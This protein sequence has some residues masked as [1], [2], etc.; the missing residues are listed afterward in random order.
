MKLHKE[1]CGVLRHNLSEDQLSKWKHQLVENAAS[2]FGSTD[3]AS[4]DPAERIAHLE[5]LVGRLT[6]ALDIKK[7]R[8]G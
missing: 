2:L 8:L 1:N 7:P 5:Q 3:K 6:V 4:Q